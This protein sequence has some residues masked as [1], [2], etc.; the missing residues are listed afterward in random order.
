MTAV[1]RTPIAPSGNTSTAADRCM[2]QE[3]AEGFDRRS[4]ERP[5]DHAGDLGLPGFG[6]DDDG[7]QDLGETMPP[8]LA[9]GA[10]AARRREPHRDA[11]DARVAALDQARQG[12]VHGRDPARRPQG[13]HL[14]AALLG[15]GPEL[16]PQGVE[17]VIHRGGHRAFQ[18]WSISM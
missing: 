12:R 8:D 10:G 13:V 14:V 16:H 18:L 5:L 4:F 7:G 1:R 2:S 11:L 6:S 9:A 15:E 17:V 3:A